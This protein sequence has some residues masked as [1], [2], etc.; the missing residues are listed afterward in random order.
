MIADW[1]RKGKEKMKI[2]QPKKLPSGSWNVRLTID[3]E[4]ISITRPTKKEAFNEAAAIKTGLKKKAAERTT[5]KEA[6]NR[7]IE[8]RSNVLSPS[9]IRGY[10]AIARTRFQTSMSLDISTATN[11]QLQRIVNR[12]SRLCSAKTLKN[13]WGFI[14]SAIEDATGEKPRVR[15]PQVVPNDLPFLTAEQIPVFLTAIHGK[16]CEIPALLALSSLRRSEI[17]DLKWTDIDLENNCIHVHGA[18]VQDENGIL[19]HRKENKNTTSRRTIPFILPPLREA[20]AKADKSNPYVYTGNPNQIWQSVNRICEKE[21]LP[22][23]GVHGLRR[24]YASLAYHLG[25]SE[26]VAM[27]TGGWSDITTMRKIY[28]KVSQKDINDQCQKYASF[29]DSSKNETKN[30]T[31]IKNT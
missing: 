11:D 25:I 26:E 29:F 6:I 4:V 31:E 13:A 19:V 20:V 17:L 2:P 24:S 10:R 8:S 27:R 16:R 15:I 21:R 9:T 28:T 5:L 22:K 30:E 1:P 3:G 7:Y 23:V 14:S 12:E 18:A